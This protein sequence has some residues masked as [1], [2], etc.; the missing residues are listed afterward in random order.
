[1]AFL[2]ANLTENDQPVANVD[3]ALT[4]HHIEDEKEVFSTRFFSPEGT[5]EW[6]QQFFD[7]ADH[8]VTLTATSTDGLFDPITAEMVIGVEAIQPPGHIVA[9]TLGLFLVLTAG[10]MFVDYVSAHWLTSRQ[11][12]TAS[13]GAV[14]RADA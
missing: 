11:M 14:E 9:R 13:A 7:G 5:V 3:Y 10:T 4:F 8:R 1:L 2:F 6:G 12:A